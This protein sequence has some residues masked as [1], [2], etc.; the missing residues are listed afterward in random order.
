MENLKLHI[1]EID[2]DYT[3]LVFSL[4]MKGLWGISVGYQI[5]APYMTLLYKKLADYQLLSAPNCTNELFLASQGSVSYNCCPED[6]TKV[7]IVATTNCCPAGYNYIPYGNNYILDPLYPNGYC[8]YY[9]E[10]WG[11]T[12]DNFEESCFSRENLKL[13]VRDMKNWDYGA[14]KIATITEL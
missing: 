1:K 9:M 3:N 11:D 2:K 7:E 8:E 4:Y 5:P 12:E 6:S 14:A 10:F 13:T